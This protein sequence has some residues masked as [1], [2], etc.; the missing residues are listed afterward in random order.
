LEVKIIKDFKAS[1]DW[2]RKNE[3]F[4]V[5]IAPGLEFSDIFQPSVQVI[6]GHRSGEIIPYECYITLPESSSPLERKLQEAKQ[7]NLMHREN[8][9]SLTAERDALQKR[10]DEQKPA[11]PR[12]VAEAI[13]SVWGRY[14]NNS[15]PKHVVLTNWRYL[16]DLAPA[17]KGILIAFYKDNPLAY[18][19]A[20]VNGYTIE[21]AP[22]DHLKS[23]VKA[24]YLDWL[25]KP[26]SGD[27]DRDAEEM[28]SEIATFV[29][30]IQKE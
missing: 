20:L 10:L 18:V 21:Q 16:D 25:D 29:R 15:F 14:E 22:E 28:A 23:G 9:R 30:S 17:K 26:G 5:R 1:G 12:E 11:I 6:E 19:N 8:V 7:E 4:T 27:P 2:F 24:I 13:E 3:K